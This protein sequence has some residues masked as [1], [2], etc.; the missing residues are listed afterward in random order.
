[1]T[2]EYTKAALTASLIN[3][4]LLL[5]M[6]GEV[7]YAINQT[8]GANQLMAF[9]DTDNAE[10]AMITWIDTFVRKH[11]PNKV[12]L[13]GPKTDHPIFQKAITKSNLSSL[14][15]A[16]SVIPPA[17]A[18]ALGIAKLAKL[19]K[20]ILESQRDDCIENEECLEVRRKA[21][22]L[23]GSRESIEQANHSA[24]TEL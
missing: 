1:M 5:W 4:P 24:R 9:P 14:I 23:A 17:H 8:L 7:V 10:Q 6:Q 20:D 13:I 22:R 11:Q 12:I 3:T 21:D 2:L 16:S 15:T 18:V 19:A